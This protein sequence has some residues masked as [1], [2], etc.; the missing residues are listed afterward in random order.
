MISLLLLFSAAFAQD[1]CVRAPQFDDLNCNNV[2]RLDE[3]PILPSDERCGVPP[4]GLLSQDDYW[5]YPLYGCRFPVGHTDI[6]GDG[7]TSAQFFLDEGS[8]GPPRDLI[9]VRCDNCPGIFNPSQ[10]DNDCDVVGNL[11]DN[12]ID[13][14][15]PGQ[16]DFDGDEFGDVCDNCPDIPNPAQN[17]RDED[18]IGDRCD[19][20]PSAYNPEQEVDADGRPIPCGAIDEEDD[21]EDEEPAGCDRER[22]LT[23]SGGCSTAESVLPAALLLPILAFRRRRRRDTPLGP[24]R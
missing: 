21:V 12:C 3:R 4:F 10:L 7:L 20:C 15:N 16:A 13:I 22:G 6:D 1:F 23:G 11:C 24:N 2:D 14:S 9:R 17:D 19:N 8:A 5:H 18:G